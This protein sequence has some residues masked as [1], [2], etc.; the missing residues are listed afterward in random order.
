M[1]QGSKYI[2]PILREKKK[3]I[4]ILG[5]ESEKQSEAQSQE[6]QRKDA[7]A[8]AGPKDPTRT[9]KDR[10]GPGAWGR[11]GFAVLRESACCHASASLSFSFCL[12]F[13]QGVRSDRHSHT[14]IV[15]YKQG[16][17]QHKNKKLKHVHP[18]PAKK[19]PQPV[20]PQPWIPQ[21]LKPMPRPREPLRRGGVWRA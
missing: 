11:E 1:F 14:C 12:H 17:V 13:C 9:L 18:Y 21:R 16:A 15:P 7:R 4:R 20:D 2:S 6:T 3:T 8:R 5:A 10:I 19:I